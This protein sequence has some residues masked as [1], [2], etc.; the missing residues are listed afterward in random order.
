[1]VRANYIVQETNL[2][3]EIINKNVLSTDLEIIARFFDN[4]TGEARIPNADTLQFV[5]NKD[6]SNFEIIKADSHVTVDGLTTITINAN[7]RNI[8]VSGLADGSNEGNAHSIGDTIACVYTHNQL[9]ES[10]AVLRGEKS[11]GHTSFT[12]GNEEGNDITLYFG[13][14]SADLPFLRLTTVNGNKKIV[15]SDDGVT[16][17]PINS[18]DVQ[19]AA[20]DGILINAGVVSI[21][22][23]YAF[24]DS[25]ARLTDGKISVDVIPLDV[26]PNFIDERSGIYFPA[27]LTGTTDA[28]SNFAIWDN[29]VDGSFRIT[30]DGVIL[31][32]ENID[33]SAI[34]NMVDVASTIQVALRAA[35]GTEPTVEWDGDQFIITSSVTDSTSAISTT[36]ATGAGTD[37]SGADAGFRGMATNDGFIVEA[38]EDISA[39]AGASVVLD[40]EGYIPDEFIREENLLTIT[41]THDIEVTNTPVA[42]AKPLDN[43]YRYALSTNISRQ[44]QD[45][46]KRLG[47]TNTQ[48]H[49]IKRVTIPNILVDTEVQFEYMMYPDDASSEGDVPVSIYSDEGGLPGVRLSDEVNNGDSKTLVVNAS[50]SGNVW[51]YTWT[52]KLNGV[53]VRLEPGTYWLYFRAE[54]LWNGVNDNEGVIESANNKN[55]S[56]YLNITEDS[57]QATTE[58]WIAYTLQNPDLPSLVEYN[59]SEPYARNFIGY[60]A[61][62]VAAGEDAEVQVGGVVK[63]LNGLTPNEKVTLGTEAN[64]GLITLGTA[65]SATELILEDRIVVGYQYMNI[66]RDTNAYNIYTSLTLDMGG[67][68]PYSP[69]SFMITESYS[70]SISTG[71]NRPVIRMNNNGSICAFSA[72]YLNFNQVEDGATEHY[73]PNVDQQLIHPSR[74][75]LDHRV[76]YTTGRNKF[77]YNL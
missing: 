60:L 75:K 70:S 62:S 57:K 1:M 32:V 49:L 4:K 74:L 25:F 71:L 12:V 52:P 50:G 38:V 29:I 28:V 7:G 55:D 68:D 61:K 54:A 59:A 36:S 77:T 17:F 66:E 14:N 43:T 31:D 65:K 51:K 48:Y 2:V 42:V 67:Y 18:N 30:L 27:S 20:G 22:E 45:D 47:V 73:Q 63:N 8:P 23:N 58:L 11:T 72:D 3:G 64:G 6:A 24:W 34:L 41:A 13:D 56:Y 37:I 5:I 69:K 26:L 21:D 9:E 19:I 35:S 16:S 53:R 40:D 15:F 39:D 10:N 33:F 76:N 44:N 46:A